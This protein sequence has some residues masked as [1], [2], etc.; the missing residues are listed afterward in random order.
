ME[1]AE[2]DKEKEKRRESLEEAGK[3]KFEDR[4]AR[5]AEQ[6]FYCLPASVTQ[7]E[8]WL[9]ESPASCDN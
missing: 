8:G 3:Q 7:V 4:L 9:L 2:Y 1:T 6:W 5:T